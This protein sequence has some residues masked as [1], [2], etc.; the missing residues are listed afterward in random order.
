MKLCFNG[1][2]QPPWTLAFACASPAWKAGIGSHPNVWV[3]GHNVIVWYT[4]TTFGFVFN[5]R[6]GKSV[7][8]NIWVVLLLLMM[9]K[10][11][12]FSVILGKMLFKGCETCILLCVLFFFLFFFLSFEKTL[13]GIVNFV[14]CCF[15][16]LFCCCCC[17][18]FFLGGAFCLS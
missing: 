12:H 1:K 5:A 4:W 18:C 11:V 8:F 13:A 10:F 15:W 3:T 17:C 7:F 14:C 2:P 16:L 9:D 6:C